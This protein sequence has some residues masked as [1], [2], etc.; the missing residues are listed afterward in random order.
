[1]AK[2]PARPERVTSNMLSRA[3]NLC[4]ARG[5]LPKDWDDWFPEVIPLLVDIPGINI[6]VQHILDFAKARINQVND[7]TMLLEA[8]QCLALIHYLGNPSP[9]TVVVSIHG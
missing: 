4:S 9:G 5:A 1:M 7:P 3:K 8:A 2:T 6:T